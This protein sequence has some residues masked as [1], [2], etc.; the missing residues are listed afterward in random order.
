MGKN[1]PLPAGAPTDISHSS[2]L[3]RM[4]MGHNLCH[5]RQFCPTLKSLTFKFH[6]SASLTWSPIHHQHEDALL[7]AWS[8]L[9]I[10]SWHAQTQDSHVLEGFY[11]TA[12]W[13]W[14]SSCNSSEHSLQGS[15]HKQ[16]RWDQCTLLLDLQYQA[17]QCCHSPVW[18]RGWAGLHVCESWS[19]T[20]SPQPLPCA[21][22]FYVAL[23]YSCKKMQQKYR[24]RSTHDAQFLRSDSAVIISF[25]LE[26]C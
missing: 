3:T 8:H 23:K 10:Y 13:S 17:Q 6:A 16:P 12:S 18:I 22:L 19:A 14:L 5:S 25:I 2:N 4:C 7:V 24:C 11:T 9:L 26:W 20:L 1:C 15:A 21:I